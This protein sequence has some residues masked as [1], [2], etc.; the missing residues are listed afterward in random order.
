[1]ISDLADRAQA[2]LAGVGSDVTEPARDV[3]AGLVVAATERTL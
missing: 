1:M 3:L 2:A